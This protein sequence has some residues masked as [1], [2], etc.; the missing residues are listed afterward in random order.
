[1]GV[2]IGATAEMEDNGLRFRLLPDRPTLGYKEFNLNKDNYIFLSSNKKIQAKVDLISD[3][4]TGLKI[5]TEHQ[6]STRTPPC[7]RTSPSASIASTW[8]N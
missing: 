6:D 3:E 1:M 2:R 4:E 7:C 8:E 5:Y